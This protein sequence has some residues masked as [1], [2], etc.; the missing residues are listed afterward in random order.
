MCELKEGETGPPV[1]NAGIY[2]SYHCVSMCMFVQCV[3]TDNRPLSPCILF[4]SCGLTKA[5]IH[6]N[7][8]TPHLR[9]VPPGFHQ[10]TTV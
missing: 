8:H 7:T 4:F 9:T 2:V 6:T 5:F 3:G 1:C 10:V